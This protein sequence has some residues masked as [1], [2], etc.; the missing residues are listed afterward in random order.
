[1]QLL[2]LQAKFREN[3]KGPRFAGLENKIAY[4]PQ[5]PQTIKDSQNEMRPGAKVQIML[6]ITE[7]LK[8]VPA[9]LSQET[10]EHC[11]TIA[12]IMT[13]NR[14]RL[15]SKRIRNVTLAPLSRPVSES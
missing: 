12:C 15:V 10:K 6:K 14:K 3:I 1:M 11:P 8:A 9:R 2:N 4:F 5:C 13:Q 7:K